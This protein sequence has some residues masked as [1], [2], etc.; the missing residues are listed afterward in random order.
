MRSDQDNDLSFPNSDGVDRCHGND[1]LPQ[2]LAAQLSGMAIRFLDA[3]GFASFAYSA[4]AAT[5]TVV[6]SNW[7]TSRRLLIGT[8]RLLSFEPAATLLVVVPLDGTPS[9]SC[10][11]TL[12][13]S[14]TFRRFEN[15]FP[16]TCCFRRKIAERVVFHDYLRS[17]LLSARVSLSGLAF[18]FFSGPK[19][20]GPPY[21]SM[22]YFLSASRTL[23]TF[24]EISVFR[25]ST[26]IEP[27]HER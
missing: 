22:R 13:G 12:R 5:S 21:L 11:S 8:K 27:R 24:A 20:P 3:L 18:F 4:C 14:A 6:D 25:R 16:H 10:R 9:L 19:L 1:F 23:R 17:L 7:S 26:M 15:V 2:K